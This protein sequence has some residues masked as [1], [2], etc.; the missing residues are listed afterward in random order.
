[1]IDESVFVL[2]DA[3]KNEI[4]GHLTPI[5]KQRALTWM[6]LQET[7]NRGDFAAMDGFFDADFTYG[8]PS[9][10][11]LGSYA[12][13]KTSPEQL[14][15]RFPPSHYRILDALAKGDDEIWVHCH[16]VGALTG[17][18][19]MGVEPK[20]QE[21]SVEWFSTIKFKE[22]LILR[23]FSIADVLGMLISVGVVDASKMP[24]DPYK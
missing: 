14:Y 4:C 1:M 2:S 12:S 22:G 21:I 7:L 23:I 17:G 8:N 11:D 3:K 16:H 6:K 13:W 10:P 24:V 18:R 20:G 19:Y 9:R 5:Q 15:K